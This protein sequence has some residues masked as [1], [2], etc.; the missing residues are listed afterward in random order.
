[1]LTP[2]RFVEAAGGMSLRAVEADA[3][4][5]VPVNA[6]VE[7]GER[8]GKR[9]VRVFAYDGSKAMLACGALRDV[10]VYV[11]SHDEWR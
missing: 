6:E 11:E 10:P 7:C 8:D 1:M 9:H 4:G 5:G 2:A 3:V